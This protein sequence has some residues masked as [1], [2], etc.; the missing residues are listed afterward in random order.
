MLTCEAMVE[1]FGE[2]G[3]RRLDVGWAREKGLTDADARILSEVGLPVRADVAFT[4]YVDE[5]L[6]AGAHV[7]FQTG[8]GE[9]DVLILGTVAP[10]GFMR[11]FLNLRGGSVGLLDLDA[12]SPSAERVNS[13][14]ENFVEFLRRLR[15]RQQELVDAAGDLDNEE[16]TERL[17]LALKEVDAAAFAHG[18]A[19]WAMVLDNVMK[20][21]FI[22]ETRAFLDQ[23]R[24]EVA[25]ELPSSAESYAE[26]SREEES[27]KAESSM[28]EF[29]EEESSMEE[30]R[31]A[32]SS[33]EDSGAED[34][35]GVGVESHDPSVAV[36]STGL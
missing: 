20:R 7:V 19:W 25:A 24:A 18:E 13:S 27:S 9:V 2:A 1:A 11:Y 5:G 31:G 36:P 12:E 32:E 29:C 26:D 10:D 28:E 23:R 4:T 16:Y 17:W 34:S 14:L 3:L 21:S 30:F 15:V 33:V 35:A 8:D 6:E 22:A